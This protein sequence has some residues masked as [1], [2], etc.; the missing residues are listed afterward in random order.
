MPEEHQRQPNG[1]CGLLTKKVLIH[2]IRQS[3]WPFGRVTLPHFQPLKADLE[4]LGNAP[5][6]SGC[7][8]RLRLKPDDLRLFRAS[9]EKDLVK[10]RTSLVQVLRALKET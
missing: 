5:K 2:A 1:K 4:A 10:L 9:P 8:L 6:E 7:A 3:L